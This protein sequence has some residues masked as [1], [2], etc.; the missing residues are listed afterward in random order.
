MSRERIIYAED[1]ESGEVVRIKGRTHRASRELE[2]FDTRM[3]S[4][5][6]DMECRGE[7]FGPGEKAMFKKVWF[8]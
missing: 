6:H 3:R 2:D 8:K 5:L 7:R 1:L 4:Q